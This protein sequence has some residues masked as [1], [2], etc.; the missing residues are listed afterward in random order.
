MAAFIGSQLDFVFFCYGLAFILLGMACFALARTGRLVE[1]WAVLGFF[2]FVHGTSEW[3]ALASLVI[4]DSPMFASLRLVVVA[5]SFVLLME[6]ARREAVRFGWRRLNAWIF[7]PFLV[8]VALVWMR[9]GVNSAEVVTRYGLGLFGA[10]GTAAVFTR[11]AK[12]FSGIERLW[13]A[14]AAL[15]FA[16]YG[17]ATGL[18]APAASFWPANVV[19][20]DSFLHVTGIPI[21]LVRGVLACGVAFAIWATWQHRLL[22][23]VGSVP[24]ADYLRRQFTLTLAMMLV[25]LACGWTLTEFLGGI[26]K[27]NVEQEARGDLDLLA[28]HLNGQTSVVDGMVRMLAGTHSVERLLTQSTADDDRRGKSVLDLGVDAAGAS[29]GYVMDRSGGIVALADPTGAEARLGLTV[30]VVEQALGGAPVFRF[31]FD[32]ASDMQNY[33]AS[34]PVRNVAGDLLGTAVLKKSLRGFEADLRE[35]DRPYFLLD[36]DG[37]VTLTNRPK[38]MFRTFW[39]IAGNPRAAAV[40]RY[41]RIDDRPMLRQQVYDAAWTM[42]DGERAYLR[43]RFIDHT[44][45]SLV[46]V[47]PTRE[48][49]AS[50]VLGI[51]ITLLV[52]TTILT[53]LFGK[54]RLIHDKIQMDKRVQLQQLAR[55][56]GMQAA[57]DP[58]TGLFNRL[59]FDQTL[60]NEVLRSERYKTPLSLILFDIDRFKSINDSRGHLAGDKVLIDLAHLVGSCIRAPDFFARWGGEEFVLLLPGSDGGMGCQVANK[61]RDAIAKFCFDDMCVTCSFGVAQYLEGDSTEALVARA[62]AALYRAKLGGR[63]RVEL[64]QQTDAASLS[65]SSYSI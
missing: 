30:P 52:T 28:S 58:L 50:R 21:Q 56:L 20:V 22:S 17:V 15:G 40:Q 39:T 38:L 9:L 24:Y 48:I 47:M 8:A 60:A 55:E 32:H 54:E 41:G 36:P 26:Y 57:T 12:G 23:S 49:F 59:K 42:I 35:L 27:Q 25:I 37:I 14:A 45:W 33:Y 34:Y 44:G 61:L 65:G 16:L 63:N 4:G 29:A 62:D 46:I 43:R 6:F 31:V 11:Y 2:G 18:V 10:L 3:L 5:G 7:V 64:A 51:I 13:A 53:Y 19:N 1:P